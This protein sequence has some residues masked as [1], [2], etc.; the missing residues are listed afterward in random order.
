MLSRR[1]LEPYSLYEEIAKEFDVLVYAHSFD[2]L[3]HNTDNVYFE[4]ERKAQV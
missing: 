2:E 3:G 1:E 4:P